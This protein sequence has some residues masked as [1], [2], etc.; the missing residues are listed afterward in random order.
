MVDTKRFQLLSGCVAVVGE[1][2]ALLASRNGDHRVSVLQLTTY[3]PLD[4]ERVGR[5]L[6]SLEE[7]NPESVR[8]TDDEQIK[9]YEFEDPSKYI[10]HDFDLEH[11]AYLEVQG[12][13]E[14]IGTLKLKKDWVRKFRNQH[15]LLFLMGKAERNTLEL[16]YFVRRTDLASAKIQS[17]LNGWEAEG[18][19]NSHFDEDS[20][21]LSYSFLPYEYPEIRYERNLTFESKAEVETS[22]DRRWIG[23]AAIFAI[24]IWLI[25]V[26]VI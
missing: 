26:Y 4:V 19:V 22:A 16:S 23:L 17:I 14:S 2:A 20:E 11:D 3:F 15:E 12:I 24:I 7:E 13:R 18:Y 25:V 6:E 8:S 10:V 1:V 9:A 5:I 21:T